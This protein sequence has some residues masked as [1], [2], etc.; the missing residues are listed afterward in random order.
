V[1]AAPGASPGGP[2]A[3]LAADALAA[4]GVAVPSAPAGDPPLAAARTAR[5]ALRAAA[6]LGPPALPALAA[7]AGAGLDARAADALERGAADRARREASRGGPP[8]P[9]AGALDGEPLALLRAALPEEWAPTSLETYAA[10]PFR[11]FV[12]LGLGVRDPDAGELDPDVRD[13]GKLLHAVLERFVAAR[14][15]RRAWPPTGDDADLAEARAVAL[16]V[17]ARFEAEGR[18]GDPAVWAARREAVLARVA[19]AVRM[20][21]EAG[22]GLVPALLEHAFGGG[23]AAP[24]LELE[25]GGER[26]RLRGRIDR[27]DASPERLLVI[28]Y[29]S[30]R[31]PKPHEAKLEPEA[32]GV[33]SFQV[34]TY[35][36][37]AARALPGRS[38]LAATYQLLGAAERLDPVELDAA[39]PRLATATATPTSTAT[40]TP[41]PT[42][43][44]T[45][46]PTATATSTSTSFAVAVVDT[47][48]RIRAGRFPTRPGGCDR[49]PHRAIC[50]LDSAAVPEEGA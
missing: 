14:V 28:D 25:A 19:R 22:G 35:L 42:A 31:D 6:R 21:A 48:R 12:Q 10:C 47:V 20:E 49:C 45:S 1:W 26:V 29:K 5:A 15:A 23:A 16:E 39:D 13:E 18:T 36:L 9:H 30:G 46:T 38:T 27:V 3:P 32:F 50:R 33:E 7:L 11:L 44:A 37:A 34:P 8:S 24:A 2:L 40:E 41:T 4:A 17:F 43:T